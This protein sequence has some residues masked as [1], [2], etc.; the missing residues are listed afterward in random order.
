MT[1]ATCPTCGA[2]YCPVIDG[3][4]WCPECERRRQQARRSGVDAYCRA[5]RFV[6]RK[7]VDEIVGAG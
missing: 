3:R 6:F 1:H 4:V 7:Q 2:L 5:V